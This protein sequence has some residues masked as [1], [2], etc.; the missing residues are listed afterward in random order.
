[1]RIFTLLL[2]LSS[3]SNMAFGQEAAVEASARAVATATEDANET[4]AS[5]AEAIQQERFDKF[6]DMMSHKVMVGR[7]TIDGMDDEE[8]REE[9]YEIKKVTKAKKGD[10]WNIFARMKFGDVDMTLPFMVEV[11]W[12]GMTPVITVDEMKL[13]GMKDSFDARVVLDSGKYAGTWRHGKVGGLMFG[14]IEDAEKGSDEAEQ[15][16]ASSDDPVDETE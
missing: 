8:R 16:G 3:L 14:R 2:V 9:K 6:I 12:A 15:S 5:Q 1:M 4:I 13:I 10:F 11:K 7:F